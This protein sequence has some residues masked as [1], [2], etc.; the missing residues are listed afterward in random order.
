MMVPEKRLG[1]AFGVVAYVQNIGLMLFPW[2]AGKIADAHT[3]VQKVGGEDVTH[4][5]YTMMMVMFSGLGI[6]GVLFALG[7]KYVDRKRK[8]GVS[9]EV[10]L[11]R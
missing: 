5:D 2:I 9:I 1:T 11:H 6:I 7:L 8:T 10:V 4:V 3:T